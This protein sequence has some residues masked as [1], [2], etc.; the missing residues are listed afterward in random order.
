MWYSTKKMAKEVEAQKEHFGNLPPEMAKQRFQEEAEA[1]W[2]KIED[3][4]LAFKAGK[5]ILDG[6]RF[7]TLSLGTWMEIVKAADLTYVPVELIALLDGIEILKSE[8]APIEL[9]IPPELLKYRGMVRLDNCG[10]A[11]LKNKMGFIGDHSHEGHI[12]GTRE[13]DGKFYFV[14]DDRT[15]HGIF[16]YVGQIGRDGN[17][18]H[19]IWWRPWVT[20]LQVEVAADPQLRQGTF[21]WPLEWRVIVQKGKI[22]AV[23]SYYIQAPVTITEQIKEHIDSVLKQ[24]QQLLDFMAAHKI[25]P[26]HPRYIDVLPEDEISF[27][28]DFISTA[29]G[30]AFLEAGPAVPVTAENIPDETEWGSTSLQ[31]HRP[32][33]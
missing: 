25:Q 8:F 32:Q 13:H 2:Q 14:F 17:I 20:A 31:L 10:S 3:C 5:N 7:D 30:P 21:K 9:E 33:G 29:A 18:Q 12:V 24:S 15:M 23:S 6:G 28:F 4:V 22:A 26:W 27:S 1:G 16:E 19:P 11:A